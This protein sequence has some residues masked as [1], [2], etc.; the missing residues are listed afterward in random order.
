[1][2]LKFSTPAL[3]LIVALSTVSFVSAP[4]EAAAQDAYVV[5]K[6]YKTTAGNYVKFKGNDENGNPVFTRVVRKQSPQVSFRS[7][8]HHR[9]LSRH[10]GFSRHHSF[11]RR[12][13][14][15]GHRSFYRSHRGHFRGHRGHFRRH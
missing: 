13:H 15:G 8:F 7:T 9:G 11:A 2:K 6:T 3:A 1:M 12:S 5:G 4:T 10:R 14:F